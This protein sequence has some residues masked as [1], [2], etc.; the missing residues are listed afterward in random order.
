MFPTNF[1]ELHTTGIGFQGFNLGNKKFGYQ[2]IIGNGIGSSDV[3]DDNKF[4]SV[5]VDLHLK[6]VKQMKFGITGYVDKFRSDAK[7]HHDEDHAPDS[8][9]SVFDVFQISN[10]AYFRYFKG[11]LQFLAEGLMVNNQ[12]DS[13]GSTTNFSAYGYAGFVINESIVPYVKYDFTSVDKNEIYLKPVSQH[14]LTIGIRYEFSHLAIAKLEYGRRSF[15]GDQGRN[16]VYFQ[17]A[18][19]F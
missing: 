16:E 5:T 8:T 17:F 14:L 18:V 13:T 2:L 19:G 15:D 12:N 10:G 3:L 7:D 4:K 1:I 6:P 9:E 11:N